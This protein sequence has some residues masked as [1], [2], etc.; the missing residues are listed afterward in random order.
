MPP[1]VDNPTAQP[2]NHGFLQHFGLD[3]RV[4]ALFVLVDSLV[5]PG[6]LISLGVFYVVELIAGAVLG[7]ITYKIQRHWYGDD[8]H[9]AIIKAL[10]VFLLT[11]I[12]VPVMMNI[13]VGTAGFLGLLRM[14][15]PKRSTQR[16]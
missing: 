6:T 12:P 3:L 4:V 2:A 5:V 14:L 16:S 11:A 8:H 7:Y 9:S 10:I 15:L 13:P 1:S